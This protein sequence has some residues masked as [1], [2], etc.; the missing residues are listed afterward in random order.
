MHARVIGMK[1]VGNVDGL[2]V[3]NSNQNSIVQNNISQNRGMGVRLS[4]AHSNSFLYNQVNGNL[5]PSFSGGMYMAHSNSNTVE[6]NTFTAN[7]RFGI[8]VQSGVRN[9]IAGNTVTETAYA[10]TPTTGIIVIGPGS[11]GNQLRSNTSSYNQNGISLGCSNGCALVSPEVGGV[12]GSQ[13]TG[14]HANRNKQWGIDVSDNTGSNVLSFNSALG[15]GQFDG[16]DDQGVPACGT[17]SWQNN[18][19]GIV[20]QPCV[21]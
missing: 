15:N 16:H 4:N 21:Q 13:I 12:T 14:N 6:T 7:A 5:S 18:T 11:T 9:F 8:L 2:S 19:F 1:L 10:S 3:F 17:N 20:N